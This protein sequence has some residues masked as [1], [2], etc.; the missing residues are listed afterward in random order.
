M[1]IIGSPP[2]FCKD[3]DRDAFRFELLEPDRKSV[4]VPVQYLHERVRLVEKDK[5]MTGKR[6]GVEFVTND[7][8]QT[9]RQ[10][11]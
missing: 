6:I 11:E 1:P 10:L 5:Q 8:D 2:G 7:A 9:A 3:E 4:A